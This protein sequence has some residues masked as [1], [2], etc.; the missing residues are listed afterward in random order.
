MKNAK[1]GIIFCIGFILCSLGCTGWNIPQPFQNKPWT[2]LHGE[3]FGRDQIAN[4]TL[5]AYTKKLIIKGKD[6]NEILTL[7]GQPQQIQVIER[8]VSE[9]WYFIYYKTH[10]AYNPLN[11]VPYP[12]KEREGE[13]V[14]Q[15]NNDKVINVVTL[16]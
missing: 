4:R 7:L 9:N 6:P 16:N 2:Y 5:V 1:I 10:V 3:Q 12:G 11:K 14:V 8:N 15:F 13:F